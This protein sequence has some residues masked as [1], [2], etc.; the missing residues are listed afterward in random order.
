[1][2]L[3]IGKNLFPSWAAAVTLVKEH[4]VG[5][6]LHAQAAIKAGDGATRLDE[7]VL[8]MTN[9]DHAID[10][11]RKLPVQWFVP[12][13]GM[14]Y[15]GYEAAKQ[16]VTLLV[17]SGLIPG[18]KERVG[19]QS[20]VAAKDA[21]V[22]G[23]AASR[24]ADGRFGQHL[25]A[26]WLEATAEDA[27][28]GVRLLEPTVGREL[29]AGINQVRAAVAQRRPLDEALVRTVGDLF[30]RAGSDLADLVQRAQ[31][32]HRFSTDAS[33]MQRSAELLG[34]AEVAARVLVADTEAAAAAANVG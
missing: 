13:A 25:A 27:I 15:R 18:A 5:A 21:F 19:G 22:A 9:F 14:Y 24:N 17:G 8:A 28:T 30:D 12:K 2:Q 23:V 31:Q 10:N 33:V 4:G 29:L 16:A 7:A 3:G 32:V 11:T 34:E 1:M 26:G 20:L 6:A